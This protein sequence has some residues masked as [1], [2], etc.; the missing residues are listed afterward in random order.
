MKFRMERSLKMKVVCTWGF[1]LKVDFDEVIEVTSFRGLSFVGPVAL[2]QNLRPRLRR[3]CIL[4][5][6]R[7][8]FVKMKTDLFGGWLKYSSSGVLRMILLALRQG[9]RLVSATQPN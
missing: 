6:G 5:G 8:L 1:D 9:K 7:L 2:M 3:E 4:P